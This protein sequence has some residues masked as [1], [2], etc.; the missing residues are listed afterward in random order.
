MNYLLAGLGTIKLALIRLHLLAGSYNSYCYRALL[1]H[2]NTCLW[3]I[4]V[5]WKAQVSRC[6]MDELD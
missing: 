4:Q 2:A 5:M 6:M 1:H 3:K